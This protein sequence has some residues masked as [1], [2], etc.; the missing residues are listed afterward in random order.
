MKSLTIRYHIYYV[1]DNTHIKI[2]AC[3]VSQDMNWLW[4]PIGPTI[5]NR[6]KGKR[7]PSMAICIRRTC[8][9]FF[10]M[11][12]IDLIEWIYTE[13]NGTML[14][15]TVYNHI[16]LIWNGFS[17]FIFPLK[18]RNLEMFPP[19]Q[20]THKYLCEGLLVEWNFFESNFFFVFNF[21]SICN[22]VFI[23]KLSD[24]KNESCSNIRINSS[25][26]PKYIYS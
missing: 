3:Y 2:I 14:Y 11:G 20:N 5:E 16:W 13:Y 9:T 21:F 17:F 4:R 6:K 26:E 23:G 10:C 22:L 8:I 15:N 19:K 24:T 25:D 7:V 1:S 18:T 12:V